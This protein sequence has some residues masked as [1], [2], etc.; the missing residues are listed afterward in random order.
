MENF[1]EGDIR[2]SRDNIKRGE[3]KYAIILSR[4]ESCMLILVPI[5][6]HPTRSHFSLSIISR[7]QIIH[8]MGLEWIRVTSAN[9]GLAGMNP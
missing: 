8:L 4:E 3:K 5:W 1:E 6:T 9:T 7:N 2:K